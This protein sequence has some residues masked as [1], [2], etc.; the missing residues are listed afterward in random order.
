MNNQRTTEPPFSRTDLSFLIVDGNEFMRSL[1]KRGVK[2]C[3]RE[4]RE[5]GSGAEALRILRG[6]APDIILVD[7]EMEPIDG[8]EFVKKVRDPKESPNPFVRII[9]V[10][11]VAERQRVLAAWGAGIDEFLVKPVSVADLLGR[12]RKVIESPRPFIRVDSY[13][14]PDRRRPRLP[15][16]GPERRSAIQEAQQL[17]QEEINA[18]MHPPEGDAPLPKDQAR[19]QA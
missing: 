19:A 8:L 1:V 7:W 9:M 2:S 3:A 4:I 16:D 17:T 18:L 15:Y 11:A 5:A 12:V 13:C 6:F 10:S 14:G